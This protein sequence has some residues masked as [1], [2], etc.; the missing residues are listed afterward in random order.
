MLARASPP[1][2]ARST[3]YSNARFVPVRTE[4]ARLEAAREAAREADQELL[5]REWAERLRRR[6]LTNNRWRHEQTLLRSINHLVVNLKTDAYLVLQHK[7]G[8]FGNLPSIS[9]T[10]SPTRSGSPTST[11]RYVPELFLYV[12]LKIDVASDG[13]QVSNTPASYA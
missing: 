12:L 7:G 5:D 2:Q 8:G 10:H 3:G 6:R 9:S 11:N 4:A 13:I 1:P